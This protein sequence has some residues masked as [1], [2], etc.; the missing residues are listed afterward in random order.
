MKTQII[1]IIS[2]LAFLSLHATL[3]YSLSERIT[4]K[5]VIVYTTIAL[6][7]ITTVILLNLANTYIK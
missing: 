6:I 3:V 7:S 1:I 4:K 2:I 5:G